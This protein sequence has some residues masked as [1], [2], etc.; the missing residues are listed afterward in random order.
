ML[1][2]VLGQGLGVLVAPGVIKSCFRDTGVFKVWR[3]RI[4]QDML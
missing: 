1:G 3:Y 2:R 4:N